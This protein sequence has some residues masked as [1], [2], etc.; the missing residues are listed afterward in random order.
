MAVSYDVLKTSDNDWDQVWIGANIATMAGARPYGSMENVA[1]AVKGERI[2][3][4]GATA[5]A[6]RLAQA[7]GISIHD[8]DGM[9][10]TPGLIDCHTH[11]VYGGNRV[12]EFEQRLCGVS[13]EDI[14][15]AGG[16]IQSTVQATRSSSREALYGSARAR[17]VRL[18][19]EGITTIEIK[20]GYGLELAAERRLLEVARDLGEKLPVSVKKT[21][22]GL[23]SLP[24]EFAAQRR[25]FVEEVSGPWL[26]ALAAAGL[27]DAVDSFCEGIAFSLSETEQ[28]LQAAKR[29]GIAA[30]LHAGQLSDMGAAQLAAKY[31][32]LSADHL[33]Y[34]SADGVRDM[35]AAGTVA[36]LLPTAYFTLRQ[37][38]PP[39]IAL[40]R[41][42]GI[43]L[44]VATDSNPG[45]SPCTSILLALSMG[46][47]L[48]GLTPDEALSGATRN[49]AR[50]LG[51]LE[52]VGTIEVGKR[53][54]LAFWR[55]ER[56]AQLCYGLGANPCAAVMHR[57][58]M[59]DAREAV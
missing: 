35:A 50:A 32:A 54:D 25:R 43:P 15:R 42:A 58:K 47:T 24:P 53:A 44:A 48:F 45:T 27:V 52:D 41:E 14:A 11:L 29:L 1:L 8:A 18:M 17:L 33:E 40:L 22:L 3:W 30:H 4:L 5:D 12:A 16:G 21:F 20:S 57:G 13:Y 46:C 36:V 31:A 10:I 28:F 2:A 56:P 26:T 9:W 38:T 19:A 51:I 7:Q 6:R 34:L 49:A 37:T 59:R 39:P 23:H 55:I